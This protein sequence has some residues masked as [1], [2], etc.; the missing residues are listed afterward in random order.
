[1]NVA[2][3]FHERCGRA[4]CSIGL[5]QGRKCAT[6]VMGKETV[7]DGETT[8]KNEKRGT[9]KRQPPGV[10]QSWEAFAA[11]AGADLCSQVRSLGDLSW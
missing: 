11:P 4:I 7:R 9:A 1:M 2:G 5:E 3:A 8:T 10:G 6:E